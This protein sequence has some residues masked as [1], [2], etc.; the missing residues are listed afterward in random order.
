M[1]HKSAYIQF[2]EST[3]PLAYKYLKQQELSLPF[4][5]A[6]V[7]LAQQH[8]LEMQQV[9]KSL[10]RLK[11]NKLYQKNLAKAED[12]QS[13]AC[14]NLLSHN[15]EQDS[16][17]MAYDFHL[18]PKG[19][20]LIEVNTNASGFLL[21]NSFCQFQQTEYQQALQSLKESFKN[22]WMI[23]TK[24]KPHLASRPQLA[25]IDQN[26]QQQKMFLEFIMFKDFFASMGWDLEIL[27]SKDL[28]ISDQN[29]D[30]QTKKSSVSKS[31]Y[32][33]SGQKIDFVYNR[34]TDFYF[35][36]HPILA[37][38]YQEGLALINPQAKDYWLLSDKNRLLDWQGLIELEAIKKYMLEVQA[39][40]INNQEEL[41]AQRKKYFFKIYR[42]Y[43]GKMAYRGA[44]LT[45]KKHKELLKY[46]SLAQEYIPPSKV[47]DSKGQEWKVDFR[48]YVYKEQIQQLTARVYQ[49]QVTQFRTPGSGFALVDIV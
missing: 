10:Y 20:K 40:R 41:W 46:Q 31:L 38:A 43:G 4:F 25:L 47:K 26:P 32:A 44:N 13:I 37:Q 19:V 6:R 18:G 24:S 35:E 30:S 9:I 45:R 14:L 2:L 23:F 22:E 36:N 17:L 29:L 42:G 27:D 48:A 8:Y 34:L 28:K 21:F 15:Q 3:Y 11:N 12:S 1:R 49:G 16:V 7:N 39:L 5:E 33:P